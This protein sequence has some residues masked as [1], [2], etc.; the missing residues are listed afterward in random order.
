MLEYCVRYL[1]NVQK[2]DGEI[3]YAE[4][5]FNTRNPRLR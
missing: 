1:G 2:N 4:N 5:N 3:N